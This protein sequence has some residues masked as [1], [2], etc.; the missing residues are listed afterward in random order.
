MDRCDPVTG[1]VC[2][3]GWE[4]SNCAKDID[5]CTV[6]PTT[7]GSDKICQ[8]L[9]GSRACNCR[10]GFAK[11]SNDNCIGM[12][13]AIFLFKIHAYVCHYTKT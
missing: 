4:G 12:K 7:C 13:F 10:A 8:N 5:E 3:D 6:N 1:C 11:D 2:K 9:E